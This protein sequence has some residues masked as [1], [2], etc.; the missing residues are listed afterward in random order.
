MR[1]AFIKT[2]IRWM[3]AI[4]FVL[5]DGLRTAKN[6]LFVR[7]IGIY[8]TYSYVF[9]YRKPTKDDENTNEPNLERRIKGLAKKT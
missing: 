8:N 9:D 4:D 1:C 6:T 7:K 5:T 2:L 3:T